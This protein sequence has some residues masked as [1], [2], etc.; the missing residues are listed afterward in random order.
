MRKFL[1]CLCAMGFFA[2]GCT[3]RLTDFTVISTKNV[4]WSKAA[5][6]KRGASRTRGKDTAYTIVFVPTGQPNMKEAI[7]RAIES[8][9]GAV[10]MVDGV[11][12]STNWYIPLIYGENSYVV[13][14]TPLIDPSLIGGK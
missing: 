11:L 5:T 2:A 8:V 12:Y 13:E 9:P 1:L 14:G 6:F 3:M 7:D 4:E 10:A